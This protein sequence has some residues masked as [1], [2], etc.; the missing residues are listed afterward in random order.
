MA[1]NTL[2]ALTDQAWVIWF[3]LMGLWTIMQVLFNVAQT[4]R[5]DSLE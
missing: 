1:E 2:L 4:I 3:C 5:D